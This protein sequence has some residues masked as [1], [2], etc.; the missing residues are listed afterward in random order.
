MNC[1]CAI[2][3]KQN[4]H[5]KGIARLRSLWNTAERGNCMTKFYTYLHCKPN[6]DP[7]YVGKG[8]GRRSKNFNG[9]SQYHKNIVT[10]YGEEN[11]V[12]FI[13][14]CDS[15]AQAHSDEIH[16]IAQLRAEGYELC[17]QTKGGDGTS[18]YQHSVEARAR[19]SAAA[20]GNKRAIGNKHNRGRKFTKAHCAKMSE[21]RKGHAKSYET[22]IN[23]SIAQIG[24]K[25]SVGRILPP[26]V[27]AK[28]SAAHKG[29]IMSG[30]A[31]KKM[32][33]A[34][35]AHWKNQEIR[36]KMLS[37]KRNR[38]QA[39]LDAQAQPVK[40]SGAKTAVVQVIAPRPSDKDIIAAVASA[41]GVST[42][43]ACDWIFEVAE[44]MRQAA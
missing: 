13:F 44:A 15:E 12:V 42:G 23:M 8:F 28:L 6:G 32:S 7:F 33:L 29:K 43:K 24:N 26:E 31:R 34:A 41:F 17:N 11:I 35:K 30:E 21:V 16:Q 10:K 1:G 40:L 20:L 5:T 36:E 4:D 19:M 37:A 25:N 2:V 22:R 38:K 9:R 18:G 14:P 27:R 3:E 39:Q